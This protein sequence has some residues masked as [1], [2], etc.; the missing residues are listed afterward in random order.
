MR[1]AVAP[2][3][4]SADEVL[5]QAANLRKVGR[6]DE[7]AAVLSEALRHHDHERAFSYQLALIEAER[8]NWAAAEPLARTAAGSGEDE[9]ASRLGQN[10][11]ENGQV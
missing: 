6:L 1:R 11:G 9:Y 8:G 10:S 4:A 2:Q 7:A 3:P 5:L